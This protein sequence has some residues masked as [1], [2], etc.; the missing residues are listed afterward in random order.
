MELDKQYSIEQIVNFIE[1]IYETVNIYHTLIL[2]DDSLITTTVLNDLTN[3]LEKKDF[4]VGV[5]KNNDIETLEFHSRVIILDKEYFD[6]YIEK[7]NNDLTNITI[8]L[9]MDAISG[10][11]L[12][13]KLI[14]N[15]E[16]VRFAEK[17][18]IFSCNK[19]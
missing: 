15:V 7:K 17:M 2:Y 9:C 1:H 19:V 14:A 12:H 11:M 16:K 4:P 8:M 18:Y 6:T 5:Y 13:D 10:K 3:R